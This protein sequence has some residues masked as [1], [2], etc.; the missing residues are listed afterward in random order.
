[1]KRLKSILPQEEYA[2]LEGMMWIIRK[3]HECLSAQD[4]I[5]LE[6]LYTHSPL[7]KEAHVTGQAYWPNKIESGQLY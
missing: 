2:K 4:K 7:L 3:N 6:L 1:M 5:T